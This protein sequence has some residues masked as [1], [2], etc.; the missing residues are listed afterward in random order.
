MRVQDQATPE[1]L[2]PYRL[3]R[4]L[5]EGG[6][7]VVYLATGSNGQLVAVKA[8]HPA[9]AA[10]ENARRR[11][12]REVETMLRVRSPYVAEV[13]DADVNGDPPYIV[14][15]YVPGLTLD[16]VV[17][18][19]GPLTQLALAK[20]AR[21]LAEA[22]A[23]VHAAGVVHRD[24]KPGN[25]MI[26]GDEPVVIDFGI[27][28]S[29]ETTRLTMTGMFMGTPG[30]LAPEVIE[31]QVSGSA[32]DVHSLGAT[33]AFAA[34]GR[35]PFGTGTFETIFYR[36]VHGQPDLDTLPVPLRSLVLRSLS[37]DPA[38]RPSA[39][40]LSRWAA[41]LDPALLVPS[42]AMLVP[43]G[44]PAGASP[45]NTVVDQ[46]GGQPAPHST[47][48][49]VLAR[50]S[51]VRDL[52]P[53]VNYGSPGAALAREG[54]FAGGGGFAGA[55]VAGGG[56]FA[57]G[58]GLP[59]GGPG[60]VGNAGFGVAGGELVGPVGAGGPGPGGRMAAGRWPA[61]TASS[62]SGWSPLV[63]GVIAV[64]AAASVLAPIVGTASS[65]IGLVALR[66][67]SIT[68]RQLAKRRSPDGR[69]AREPLMAI[70]LYPLAVLR[71]LITL[72]LLAPVALLG[73]G[74]TAAITII[75]VP[76]HPLP[77]AMA[78][79]A[80]TLVAIVGLGPGSAG[81]R[82]TLASFFGSVARTP[83][84]LVVAYVGV[85]A[86]AAWAGLTAVAQPA[87]Y[88]PADSLHTQLMHLPTVHSML[89]D[90]RLNLLRLARQLGL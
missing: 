13:I 90:A 76:A 43:G 10:E 54:G 84:R 44:A 20:L 18:E 87:A 86:V 36:I 22:L 55:A 56:G 79:G 8:L 6:M 83:A 31:G 66:A 46:P 37:R 89:T 32:A 40:D 45:P 73:F 28:Q 35:P 62:L 78:F 71:A 77:R 23:A 61:R 39:A 16:A 12:A 81:G 85:L 80:G 52:L 72:L 14:T 24:L 2:G 7:G 41:T 60:W 88:W 68:G 57:G 33:L 15:R 21:G 64:M 48:P 29:P 27:A 17:G 58:A 63:I 49:L 11:L 65:L 82:K 3:L 34:T 26:T 69:R 47:R 38:T 51:D 70:A 25:V 5:G 53:P 9:M 50:P 74:I 59:A 75:A 30:Y 67:A 4:R 1:R 42:P 19:R